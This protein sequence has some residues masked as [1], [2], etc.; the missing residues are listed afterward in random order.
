MRVSNFFFFNKF[1]ARSQLLVEEF[2]SWA[3]LKSL[4]SKSYISVIS[5][6]ASMEG[7]FFIPF[8][9]FL[10]WGVMGDF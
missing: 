9:I 4:S 3:V 2:L 6:L 8:E 5:V 10:A 1:Q 7:L